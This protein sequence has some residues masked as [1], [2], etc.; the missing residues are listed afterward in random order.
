MTTGLSSHLF[1]L[2]RRT[3][4]LLSRQ[5]RNELYHLRSL[6]A[7]NECFGR[8]LALSYHLLAELCN[9]LMSSVW[10]AGF[11]KNRQQLLHK[12]TARS[13]AGTATARES[14]ASSR[15]QHRRLPVLSSHRQSRVRVARYLTRQAT[16][17][18]VWQ[19]AL[20]C[21]LF[22]AG[23]LHLKSSPARSS[24]DFEPVVTKVN[25]YET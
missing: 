1:A 7:A 13:S 11:T 17:Q 12:V 4:P 16:F 9:Y 23:G 18:T 10:N 5:A 21:S 6:P 3:L 25:G 24:V 2:H 22:P 15:N 8:P 19:C 20:I 14:L